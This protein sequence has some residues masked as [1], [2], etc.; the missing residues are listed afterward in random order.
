M[1]WLHIGLPKTGSSAIQAWLRE[2]RELLSQ[3]GVFYAADPKEEGGPAWSITS[4]NAVGLARQLSET[5]E[6]TY[7]PD[8]IR[9]FSERYVSPDHAVS[10]VSS[11][12]LAAALPERLARLRDEGIGGRPVRVLALVRDHYG[13]AF[14]LWHQMIK[15]SGFAGSFSDFIRT[16]YGDPQSRVLKVFEGAFGRDAITLLHYDTVSDRLIPAVFEAMGLQPPA[17]AEAPVVNRSLTPVEAEVLAACNSMH[18]G[19][20]QASRRLSD[21]LIYKHPDRA[22]QP[23]L[24]EEAAALIAARCG[25]SA[26]AIND[27]YF[28]GRPVLSAGPPKL[29]DAAKPASADEVWRDVAE[30]LLAWNGELAHQNRELNLINLVL[31]ASA[32]FRKGETDSAQT[33]LQ[34]ALSIDPEHPQVRALAARAK[35]GAFAR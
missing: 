5:P 26:A 3:A 11:E 23:E 12:I 17:G 32:R 18:G 13:H 28:D 2:H 35:A 31:K 9:S 7:D 27:R 1:I 30:A 15:R 6:P 24:D 25:P 8:P 19:S 33:L 20:Q 16:A 10:L 34:R 29:T 14:S 22:T 21:H 4:G